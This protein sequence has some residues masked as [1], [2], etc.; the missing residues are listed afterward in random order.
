LSECCFAKCEI[1]SSPAIASRAPAPSLLLSPEAFWPTS[2]AAP[3]PCG[4]IPLPGAWPEN[5]AA[6][7]LPALA[8][9]FDTKDDFPDADPPG[10]P[11]FMPDIMPANFAA[12]ILGTELKKSALLANRLTGAVLGEGLLDALEY[13]SLNVLGYGSWNSWAGAGRDPFP[14]AT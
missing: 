5:F 2:P 13:G 7:I 3:G 12:A 8:T 11:D 4:D 10:A 9:R 6:A 14:A 1:A